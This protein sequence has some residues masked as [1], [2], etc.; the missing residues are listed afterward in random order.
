MSKLQ[1]LAAKRRQQA[2]QKASSNESDISATPDNYAQSLSKLRLSQ[3][4]VAP[5]KDQEAEPVPSPDTKMADADQNDASQWTVGDKKID[6]DE[7]I[8][9]S[10]R[11]RAQPS[12]FA[13]ILTN[14]TSGVDV[15]SS[16]LL[17]ENKPHHK[18]FDFTEPSPDDL[19]N[20]AQNRL[21]S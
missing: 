13:S 14:P 12:A 3:C 5:S 15:P 6:E 16:S 2:A 20:K 17:A 7:E 21:R 11:L 4:K 18:A 9:S 8:V 10:Q 1:A 19:I